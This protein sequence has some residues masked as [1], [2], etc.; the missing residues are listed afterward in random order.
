MTTR[1]A[2]SIRDEALALGYEKC[3]MISLPSLDGFGDEVERRLEKIPDD[4][5]KKIDKAVMDNFSSFRRLAEVYP[6]AKSVVIC[7]MDYGVYEIPT[8]LKGRVARYFCVDSRRDPNSREYKA[9]LAFESFLRANGLRAETERKYGLL[10]LRWA[11][12]KAGM[13]RGRKNNFFYTQNGSWIHLE[14]WLVDRGLELTESSE[15]KPCPKDCVLCQKACPTGA[16]AGA[17][18]TRPASCLTFLN[19]LNPIDW[20]GHPQ[21]GAAGEWI[22]GCDLCQTAC[23]FNKGQWREDLEFPGLA[24]LSQ[25]LELGRI[26][27]L[28]YDFIRSALVPKFW[29]ITADRDWQ[30]KVNALNAMKNV[31]APE[32]GLAL[33]MAL[34]DERV[35][36]RKMAGWVA[37]LVEG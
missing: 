9:S 20:V 24:E 7:V 16:L 29:Y 27:E 10:P 30:W 34:A 28:S 23:P 17:Y 31:W 12:H 35:E 18:L 26:V 32:R 5:R 6:W 25:R 21:S 2:E 37:S 14:A 13:G 15:L 1:L 11:A 3:A 19:A 4:G 33:K 8:N 22:Y 36:V